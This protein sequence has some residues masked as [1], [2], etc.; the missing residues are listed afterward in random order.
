[1]D[2]NLYLAYC[3][4]IAVLMMIPGP[5]V[6]MIVANSVAHGPRYGMLTVAGTTTATAVQLLV[7]SLG[8]GSLLGALAGWFEW[9]RWI[10]V[11][12]LLFLGMRAWFAPPVDLTAIPAQPRS[13]HSLYARAFLVALTNPKTLFFYGAF[14]PQFISPKAALGP[15][16]ALLSVT[17]L[18]LAAGF[19]T[20]W[21][22]LASRLRP[23]LARRGRLRNRVTGGMLIA[24]GLGLAAARRS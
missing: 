12:Y 7:T 8:M 20:G 24:A 16:L 13:A 19:D 17:C 6:G 10:G 3:A 1:M 14:F 2:L 9:L 23:L 15:Q 22:F 5:N 11:A 18:V 4:A 21:A